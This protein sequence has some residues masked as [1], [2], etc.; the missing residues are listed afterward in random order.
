M[1]A[2]KLLDAAKA[3]DVS[4][5]KSYLSPLLE[6]L[7]IT[8]EFSKAIVAGLVMGTLRTNRAGVTQENVDQIKAVLV[9]GTCDEY[10]FSVADLAGEYDND[11]LDILIQHEPQISRETFYKDHIWPFLKENEVLPGVHIE[12]KW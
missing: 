3:S 7:S 9:E 12:Y 6:E 2:N 4:T 8:N 1:S 11:L 5:S 10:H